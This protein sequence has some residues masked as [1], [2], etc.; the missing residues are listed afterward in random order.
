M[1]FCGSRPP[2][3]PSALGAGINTKPSLLGGKGLN[4]EIFDL[5]LP[6]EWNTNIIRG[7]LKNSCLGR[8]SSLFNH[9]KSE[10]APHKMWRFA[11]FQECFHLIKIKGRFLRGVNAVTG[12]IVCVPLWAY[13]AGVEGSGVR[14]WSVVWTAWWSWGER[15]ACCSHSRSAQSWAGT[16]PWGACWEM[17]ST[18]QIA[19]TRADCRNMGVLECMNGG[20]RDDRV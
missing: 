7:L 17:G 15:G 4:N 13:Q 19:H 5:S 3:T 12:P 6:C 2:I 14:G 18:H 8:K 11:H 10:T 9:G 20:E 16:G 1:G